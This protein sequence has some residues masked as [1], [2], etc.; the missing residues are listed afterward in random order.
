[1][2][3]TEITVYVEAFPEKANFGDTTI[4]LPEKDADRAAFLQNCE[5]F[6]KGKNRP[7]DAAKFHQAIAQT[8]STESSQAPPTG[9]TPPPPGT[10]SQLPA[11]RERKLG[12]NPH[13]EQLPA[14][15]QKE[16]K[17]A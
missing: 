2:A 8:P 4:T 17:S 14:D 16:P 10:A 5:N 7:E 13:A 11:D 12:G 6:F 3:A 9:A 15:A 1:M